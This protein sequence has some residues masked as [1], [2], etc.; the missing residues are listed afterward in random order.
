MHGSQEFSAWRLAVIKK[1][2]FAEFEVVEGQTMCIG[3]MEGEVDFIHRET[4]AVGLRTLHSGGSSSAIR[5]RGRWANIARI[6]RLVTAGL[7]KHNCRSFWN[8]D[9]TG[10]EKP[11]SPA[12]SAPAPNQDISLK[13]RLRFAVWGSFHEN[14]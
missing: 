6:S 8:I 4:E 3:S 2:E 1:L 11:S 13:T 12:N 5:H 14:G 9:S 10:R 7:S